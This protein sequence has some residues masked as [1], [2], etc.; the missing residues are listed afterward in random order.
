MVT[1]TLWYHGLILCGGVNSFTHHC[2]FV[3]SADVKAVKKSKNIR[4]EQKIVL[5]VQ[6]SKRVLGS[7]GGFRDLTLRTAGPR[8]RQSWT[9]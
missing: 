3:T 4:I 7:P 2:L 8:E 1:S 5:T 9:A 6:T